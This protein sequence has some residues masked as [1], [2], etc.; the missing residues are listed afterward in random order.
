[1]SCETDQFAASRFDFGAFAGET[2]QL[3]LQN[4][5]SNGAAVNLN[6]YTVRMQVRARV[7]GLGEVRFS[8]A[9]G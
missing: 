6:G 7:A 2:Y 8:V 3:P 9:P 1:M 5:D 4:L